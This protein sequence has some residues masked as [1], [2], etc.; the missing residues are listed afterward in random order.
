MA[1]FSVSTMKRFPDES[2]SSSFGPLNVALDAGPPSPE[3][4]RFPFPAKRVILPV[5]RLIDRIALPSRSHIYT[6]PFGPTATARGP[7]R[8]ASWY[9]PP[10]PVCSFFTFPQKVSIIPVLRSSTRMRWSDTSAMYRCPLW[11]SAR[12][13]GSRNWAFAPGPPSPEKP[14]VPLPAIRVMIPVVPSTWWTQ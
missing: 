8:D 11:S 12:P 13:L 9:G 7:M 5:L 4:P 3:Y 2:M 6:C 10:S 14:E 1:W